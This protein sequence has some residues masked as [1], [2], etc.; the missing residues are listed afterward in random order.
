MSEARLSAKKLR[1]IDA[2][3]NGATQQEAAT[4][5][6]VSRNTLQN[7]LKDD[8]FCTVLH[9]Q[10]RE[11]LQVTVRKIATHSSDAADV[12]SKIMHDEGMPAPA[13]VAAARALLTSIRPMFELTDIMPL[14]ERLKEL[15]NERS[16]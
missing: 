13:R 4:A 2:L 9:T 15:L 10:Q 3:M 14:I 8:Q 6:G 12:L 11:M 16:R 7:W 1:A 5:A